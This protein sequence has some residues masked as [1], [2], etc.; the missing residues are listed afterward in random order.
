MELGACAPHRRR[1]RGGGGY[2]GH[3]PSRFYHKQRSALS[4]Q[5]KA[6]QKRGGQSEAKTNLTPCNSGFKEDFSFL[7]CDNVSHLHQ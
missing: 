5:H 6:E 4:S 7:S 2:W 3:V 1:N